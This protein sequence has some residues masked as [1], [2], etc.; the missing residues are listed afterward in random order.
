M[1][2]AHTHTH[3]AIGNLIFKTVLKENKLYWGSKL[4]ALSV[5]LMILIMKLVS[6]FFNSTALSLVVKKKK[7]CG[8]QLHWKQSFCFQ[9]TICFQNSLFWKK[10]ILL[11]TP[12]VLFRKE[13]VT[14]KHR[15]ESPLMFKKFHVYLKMKDFRGICLNSTNECKLSP[16]CQKPHIHWEMNNSKEWLFK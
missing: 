3:T 8:I 16:V 15:C 7:H 9:K 14:L 11:L 12:F 2:N 5:R 10:T 13:E 1:Q 6:L 4:P